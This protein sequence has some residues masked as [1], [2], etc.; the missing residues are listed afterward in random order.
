M[1]GQSSA[2]PSRLRTLK[3]DGML[4][5]QWAAKMTVPPPTPLYIK[6]VMSEIGLVDGIV[7]GSPAHVRIPGP[8]AA[9][10]Q[11]EVRLPGPGASVIRPRSLLQADDAEA[12]FA[13]PFRDHGPARSG[14]HDQDIRGRT[15]GSVPADATLVD[16]EVVHPF[17]RR[18]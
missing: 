18:P 17:E 13:E 1:S 5:C 11:L 14:A 8:I 3:S 7:R 12:R 6:A 10:G 4:R 16:A 15:G 9:S 2:M